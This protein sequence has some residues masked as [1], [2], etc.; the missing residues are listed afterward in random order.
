MHKLIKNCKNIDYSS[1]HT[2]F[3]S[4]KSVFKIILVAKPTKNHTRWTELEMCMNMHS[5]C[6]GWMCDICTAQALMKFGRTG[7]D[8]LIDSPVQ[9]TI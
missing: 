5:I 1:L 6:T 4:T 2:H 9:Q 7:T 3:L 8:G